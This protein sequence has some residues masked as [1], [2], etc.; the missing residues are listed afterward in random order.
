MFLVKWKFCY[1]R[2]CRY[3]LV[4]YFNLLYTS[5]CHVKYFLSTICGLR[6]LRGTNLQSLSDTR[7]QWVHA[8]DT[9]LCKFGSICFQTTSKKNRTLLKYPFF[10]YFSWKFGLHASETRTRTLGV[11]TV[12]GE[13]E[14]PE[15][16]TQEQSRSQGLA[17]RCHTFLHRTLQSGPCI[18]VLLT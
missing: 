18:G 10:S 8:H 2:V 7:F 5:L 11:L 9:Y 3:N 16:W 13:T 17:S 6:Y 1:I 12:L 4:T 14:M 15:S